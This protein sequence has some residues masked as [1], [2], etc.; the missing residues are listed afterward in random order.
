MINIIAP[1][2]PLAQSWAKKHNYRSFIYVTDEKQIRR[3]FKT[4]VLSGH[5]SK[6]KQRLL[7]EVTVSHKRIEYVDA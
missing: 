3:E 1:N 4:V 6:E 7:E 2:L 5:L